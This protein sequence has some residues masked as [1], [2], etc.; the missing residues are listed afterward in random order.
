MHNTHSQNVIISTDECQYIQLSVPNYPSQVREEDSGGV[1]V[2]FSFSKYP[3]T[4]HR[5]KAVEKFGS[6]FFTEE[7]NFGAPFAVQVPTQIFDPIFGNVSPNMLFNLMS[8]QYID[9]G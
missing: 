4:T 1:Q 8:M 6:K 2:T 7:N 3:N 9:V 5:E